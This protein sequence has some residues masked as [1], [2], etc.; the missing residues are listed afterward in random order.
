MGHFGHAKV[1][2][3]PRATA[4]DLGTR[5]PRGPRP[6]RGPTPASHRTTYIHWL[7]IT[8]MSV[9]TKRKAYT[10]SARRLRSS[11]PGPPRPPAWPPPPPRSLI[12]V[13]V[14]SAAAG[15]RREA[16][17]SPTRARSP[18][19]AR[20]PPSVPPVPVNGLRK[21]SVSPWS[22]P[23]VCLPW[24]C[25]VGRINFWGAAGSEHTHRPID[26]SKGPSLSTRRI[27]GK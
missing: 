25:P 26:R 9:F 17:S 10:C 14:V 1:E 12:V 2:G 27:L 11:P 7:R 6:R 24:P 5:N 23:S 13:V 15:S 18:R 21:G 4:P 8:K 19:P 20:L 16:A 22:H 3:A